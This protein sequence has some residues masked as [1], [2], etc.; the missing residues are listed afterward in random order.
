MKDFKII[1]I[2]IIGT[3]LLFFTECGVKKMVKKQN[4]ISYQI[5]SAT[6][7]SKGGKT[8]IQIKGTFPEKYFN[9]KVTLTSIPVLKNP[10]GNKDTLSAINF[11]GEKAD[12]SGQI[13][14]YKKGSGFSSVQTIHFKPEF[15]ESS[16]YIQTIVN[17]KGKDYL[18][19]ER[20]IGTINIKTKR[21]DIQPKVIYKSGTTNEK[22]NYYYSDHN[23]IP[24][25]PIEKT[26]AIYFD[27][28]CDN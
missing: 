17:K 11:Q 27:F 4:D 1:I 22:P 21:E 24:N 28:N 3:L 12:G 23:Y 8:D 18:F 16:L 25:K 20:E 14:N 5:I 10:E 15:Q 7:D 13:I 6:P 2:F 19:Q 9:K 26:A